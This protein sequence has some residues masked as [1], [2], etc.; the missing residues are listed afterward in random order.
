MHQSCGLWPYDS[1]IFGD[2]DFAASAVTEEEYP[3]QANESSSSVMQ[4]DQLTDKLPVVPVQVPAQRLED[5]PVQVIQAAPVQVPEAIPDG[6]DPA[7]PPANE[8]F[9]FLNRF[10]NGYSLG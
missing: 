6:G 5:V 8:G 9:F 2:D 4:D 7:R 1:N 3:S 10:F